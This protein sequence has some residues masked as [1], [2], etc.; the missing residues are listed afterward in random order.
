MA[1]FE[2]RPS[3]GS[4]SVPARVDHGA[5]PAWRS[6][7]LPEPRP[8]SLSGVLRTIGPGAILLAASIG[9][10]EWVAGPL[11]V[12]NHGRG[13]LW[14]A[15]VAIVLQAFVNLE[16]VRYTLYTGEPI[17][18]GIMRLRPG[19]RWWGGLYV[20]L[21]MAQLG[22][23]SLAASCA[24]VVFAMLA[25][26]T[27]GDADQ[28]WLP[29]VADGLVICG[30]LLLISGRK[31]ERVL[32]RL[33]WFMIVFI[34]SFL[35][36]V[37]VWFVSPADWGRTARGFLQ[38]GFVP[39]EMDWALLG[40]FAATA[41]SGGLGNLVISNWFRDK[42]FGMGARVGAIGGA[43]RG[44]DVTLAAVGCTFPLTDVN[45][46][47]WRTWWRYT[48]IDQAGLWACGCV[49]GMFLNVNIAAAII[50]PGQ[51]LADLAV[52]T[53]Q[54]EYMAAT[55]WSGFWVL[56][57]LNGFWIL[58]STHLGN[59]DC[60]VRV[61]TDIGWVAAPRIQRWPVSRIYGALLL[62]LTAWGLVSV[63]WGSALNLFKILGIVAGPT[64]AFSSLQ[65]LRVNTRFL[66]PELRPGLVSRAG[67]L[68]CSAFYTLISCAVAQDLLFRGLGK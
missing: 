38:F 32:E 64:L 51:K 21:G 35:V 53:F 68:L 49:V 42:G 62:A 59:T 45:R 63:H 13:I 43:L 55:I 25:R 67:L 29:W 40:L 60:L 7:D 41:G 26:R 56:A 20:G 23:P 1:A 37:N 9:G 50:P 5:L 15:S 48:L 57:L 17:L 47:R 28:V 36:I 18:T 24:G 4:A 65:I 16:A 6:A 66:P 31:V 27:P 46:A 2:S 19:S 58:F 12:V 8:F 61:V 52:G 44:S 33:S 10:G 34:M 30:T 39:A 3:P 14:I 22:I 54:A 11:N